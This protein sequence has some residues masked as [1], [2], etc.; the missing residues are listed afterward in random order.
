MMFLQALGL[1]ALCAVVF[2]AV[3]DGDFSDQKSVTGSALQVCSQPGEAT[4][5][6]T[7]DGHCLAGA[8]DRGSHHICIKMEQDFCDV[9][10]Q[11]D[12]CSTLRD[13]RSGHP[14]GHWCVCQWAFASYLRGKRNDCAAFSSVNC[15]ATNALALGA[16]QTRPEYAD[17]LRC[18][19]EKCGVGTFEQTQESAYKAPAV[20]QTR[21]AHE[22]L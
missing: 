19:N 13:P 1:S 14:I 15:N 22:E 20:E 12:W 9:T 10:N 16:Y 17:A 18:L 5:G 11:G 7:R 21:Q 4:T 8:N 3:P 6:W 2:G